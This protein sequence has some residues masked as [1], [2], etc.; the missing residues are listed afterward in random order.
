MGSCHRPRPRDQVCP[1]E[2]ATLSPNRL[3][4]PVPPY[5]QTS[6]LAAPFDHSEAQSLAKMRLLRRNWECFGT[7]LLRRLWHRSGPR[8]RRRHSPSGPE[9]PHATGQGSEPPVRKKQTW[10][11]IEPENTRK[12]QQ[13]VENSSRKSQRRESGDTLSSSIRNG[14]DLMANKRGEATSTSAAAAAAQT[15][16]SKS[17]SKAAKTAAASAL[18][19][20]GSKEV[21][22]AKAAS[23]AAKAL[24]D[25]KSSKAA[26]TAAASALTQRP[27][28][29]KR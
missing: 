19:Q 20:R 15:L 28:K 25:P 27:G 13:P 1:R 17:A 4:R 5:P 12:P 10:G 2:S 24:R 18:T 6:G 23:A 7:R 22:S 3:A 21:T 8:H 14:E 16:R 29:G 11:G 26:K 9:L